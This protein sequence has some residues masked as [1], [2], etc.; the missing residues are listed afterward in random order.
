MANYGDHANT[1]YTPD[2]TVEGAFR[3]QVRD[4]LGLAWSTRDDQ[5]FDELR[6][7]KSLEG[8]VTELEQT[9]GDADLLLQEPNA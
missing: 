8:R 6:R 3:K 7:L 1:R 4:A 9:L 5:I 2:G